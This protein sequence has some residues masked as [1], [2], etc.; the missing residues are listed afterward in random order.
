MKQVCND[1]KR[2]TD[3]HKSGR[4][5][6]CRR[7]ADK[8][9]GTNRERGYDAQFARD[10]KAPE[11]LASTHCVECGQPFTEDNPRTAGHVVAIRDGGQGSGV[12]PQCR[13]CN[14]G[15]RRTGL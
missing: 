3:R 12:V 6:D 1:C 14:Y 9:R 4:C 8:Q 2:I 15:W 5:L 10:R 11:Y 7:A 13:R